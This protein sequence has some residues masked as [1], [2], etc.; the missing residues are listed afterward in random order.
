MAI[1][2]S[3]SA[4]SLPSDL[5][6]VGRAARLLGVSLAT[7]RGY[8]DRG[9]LTTFKTMGAHRRVSKSECLALLTGAPKKQFQTRKILAYMRVSTNSQSKV[10]EGKSQLLSQRKRVLDYIEKAY[11]GETVVEYCETGSAMNYN[12]KQLT[13]ML[14]SI[15]S[16]ECDG[17]TLVVEFRDRIFRHA[18][19]LLELICR[20]HNVEIVYV[21]QQDL[22]DE[23]QLQADLLSIVFLY[24][25]RS[26]SKRASERKKREPTAECIA[27]GKALLDAGVSSNKIHEILEQR[28]H[29]CSKWMARRYIFHQREKLAAVIPTS[30]SSGV[31]YMKACTVPGEAGDRLFYDTIYGHYERWCKANGKIQMTRRKFF[32]VFTTKYGITCVGVA[33]MELPPGVTGRTAFRGLR[34]KGEKLHIVVRTRE[35]NGKANPLDT[36]LRFYSEQLRGKEMVGRAVVTK[37]RAYLKAEGLED[38]LGHTEIYQ[39]LERMGA[40]KRIKGRGFLYRMN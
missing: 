32:P 34:I 27:E 35:R 38:S 7:V 21:E 36:F 31:E 25:I 10:K 14:E 3:R 28:G 19:E 8:C 1:L 33:G 12:R 17:S 16:G 22:T 26:Y 13:E 2:G 30:E 5:V 18:I 37:Y 11:P 15:L 29:Q 6:S 23:A 24:G 20:F 4:T 40:A 39:A 9:H